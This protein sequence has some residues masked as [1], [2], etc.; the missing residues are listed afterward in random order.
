MTRDEI[1]CSGRTSGSVYSEFY[2]VV[3]SRRIRARNVFKLIKVEVETERMDAS[4]G[5]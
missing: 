1:M 5:F 4:V 2:V 3:G